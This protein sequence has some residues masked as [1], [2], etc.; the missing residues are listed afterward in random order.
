MIIVQVILT[1]IY[2]C[3]Q[4]FYYLQLFHVFKFQFIKGSAFK[5]V[6]ID[7]MY[8]IHLKEFAFDLSFV[9]YTGIY[10]QL[11]NQIPLH[12]KKL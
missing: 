1:I 12:S 11:K 3:V 4:S 7:T 8:I 2:I 9:F 6:I 10:C 5:I